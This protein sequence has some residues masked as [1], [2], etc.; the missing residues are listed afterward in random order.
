MEIA[1][2]SAPAARA[3]SPTRHVKVDPESTTRGS[4]IMGQQVHMKLH[5][6]ERAVLR[7]A[8]E[9]YAGYVSAGMVQLGAENEAEMM[10][11][12]IQTAIS[13]A[14]RVDKLIQSDSELPGFL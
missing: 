12:S 13:M 11:R 1:L 5:D 2:S 4:K 7:A 14:R 8:C 6:S 9:I 10:E 3:C